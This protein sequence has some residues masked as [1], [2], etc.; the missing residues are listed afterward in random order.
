MSN[1]NKFL[2]YKNGLEI[3]SKAVESKDL[4]S[5]IAAI[6]I[7]ESIISDR[8][9]SYL[10]FKEP[11]MFK[12]KSRKSNN[13]ISSSKLV[14]SCNK[15]FVKEYVCINRK[16]K[17]DIIISLQ[18]FEEIKDWLNKRNFILHSFA[19]S[20]KPSEPTVSY[21]DFGLIA[22]ST[23]ETGYRLVQLLLKWHKQELK[24]SSNSKREV[25]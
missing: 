14:N 15:Y 4:V 5:C 25:F 16:I 7:I 17:S 18:L 11:L 12:S 22:I 1:T 23:V 6:A 10:S 24:K 13:F 19:K 21:N 9:I 3:I 20:N 2:S 8:C